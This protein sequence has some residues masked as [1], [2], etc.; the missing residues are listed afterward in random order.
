MLAPYQRLQY[1]ITLV[2]LGRL[3][4]ARAAVQAARAEDPNLGRTAWR[5]A[6]FYADPAILPAELAAL[7]A[8][9]LPE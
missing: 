1:A 4:E 9:G 3:D 2:R 7:T 6:T 5:A 8:A